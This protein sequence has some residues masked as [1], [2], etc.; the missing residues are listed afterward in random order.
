MKAK[1]KLKIKK[2][3]HAKICQTLWNGKVKNDINSALYLTKLTNRFQQL[4]QATDIEEQWSL[5]KQ[6]VGD[7]AEITVG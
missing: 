7:S 5:F 2:T 1:L 4:Q 3:T 6:A